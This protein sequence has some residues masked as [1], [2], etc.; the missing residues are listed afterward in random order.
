MYE[1]TAIIKNLNMFMKEKDTKEKRKAE[2]EK[3]IKALQKELE[4]L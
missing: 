1:I 4:S 2:I 3:Q